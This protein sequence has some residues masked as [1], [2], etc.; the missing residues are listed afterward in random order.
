MR[1]PMSG[2]TNCGSPVATLFVGVAFEARGR[3][4]MTALEAAPRFDSVFCLAL[5]STGVTGELF[6]WVPVVGIL[7]GVTGGIW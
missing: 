3:G 1:R 6:C 7:L 4:L 2:P 5:S